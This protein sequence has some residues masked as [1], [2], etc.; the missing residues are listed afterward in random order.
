MKKIMFATTLILLMFILTNR[1]YAGERLS[2]PDRLSFL[3]DLKEYVVK[4]QNQQIYSKPAMKKD[5]NN[6]ESKITARLLNSKEYQSVYLKFN[7]V[8]PN[9]AKIF[10]N[11][12]K[13]I[14]QKNKFD[15]LH[16][17]NMKSQV[18]KEFN[19]GLLYSFNKIDGYALKSSLNPMPFVKKNVMRDE[20]DDSNNQPQNDQPPMDPA[21][22]EYMAIGEIFNKIVDDE[23]LQQ[24]GA[25]VIERSESLI[26]GT[27]DKLPIKCF[28]WLIQGAGM[29]RIAL[30]R[31]NKSRGPFDDTESDYFVAK[32]KEYVK[33]IYEKIVVARYKYF[34]C[35]VMCEILIYK[36]NY[37]EAIDYC[38]NTKKDFVDSLEIADKIEFLML[39]AQITL[40]CPIDEK[41]LKIGTESYQ[42]VLK[43]VEN[44]PTREISWPMSP[45]QLREF[46]ISV[47]N[48]GIAKLYQQY[49]LY[50][51]AITELKKALA[52]STSEDYWY[53]DIVN[54]INDLTSKIKIVVFTGN[55]G[56]SEVY[57]NESNDFNK[58]DVC[59]LSLKILPGVDEGKEIKVNLSYKGD[60]AFESIDDMLK[61]FSGNYNITD[62]TSRYVDKEH[63]I[64][65]FGFVDESGQLKETITLTFKDCGEQKIR[66][67]CSHYGGDKFTI[68]AQISGDDEIRSKVI[69]VW[70]KY[71]LRLYSMKLKLVDN[72]IG[73]FP[74]VDKLI[75]TFN[76]CY[77]KFETK[78]SDKSLPFHPMIAIKETED[79]TDYIIKLRTY[80]NAIKQSNSTC[81]SK[82]NFLNIIGV[83]GMEGDEHENTTN[84]NGLYIDD[85]GNYQLDYMP[86]YSIFMNY[87]IL[88]NIGS[89]LENRSG[90]FYPTI[91][92]KV[93]IHEAGHAFGIK[94]P[95]SDDPKYNFI[96][97]A[98]CCMYRG[99]VNFPGKF[100]ENCKKLIKNNILF[101]DNATYL[102]L[103]K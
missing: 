33:N 11:I 53:E 63:K 65:N 57:I 22:Q 24:Y 47:Y 51:K 50:K 94:H 61:N 7:Q 1:S 29:C 40:E 100:C 69:Q 16:G 54:K 80:A 97:S 92:Y 78:I 15:I 99:T 55:L 85:L 81:F 4:M 27:N 68:N 32:L 35:F 38:V 72:E 84:L 45:E 10:A 39:M 9:R 60:E 91:E 46:T 67:K 36:N 28:K 62:L 83:Y 37:V 89:A 58:L 26:T 64:K 23:T 56:L 93:L 12:N 71:D 3:L 6:L 102:E 82:S 20:S 18:N 14:K 95:A 8:N 52:M 103:K 49:Q 88:R 42:A 44:P 87:N 25:E 17:N 41:Y 43:I 96:H 101:I 31:E 73:L 48:D 70:K 19:E 21:I 74:D 77:V 2:L 90:F 86:L 98:D 59:E 76:E 75:S 34:D 5:I 30:N 66:F 13:I 79:E